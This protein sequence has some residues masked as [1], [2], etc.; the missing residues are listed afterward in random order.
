[1]SKALEQLKVTALQWH[2]GQASPL[3]AFGCTATI[4]PGMMDEIKECL[5][6]VSRKQIRQRNKLLKLQAHVQ[7]QL[8]KEKYGKFNRECVDNHWDIHAHMMDGCSIPETHDLLYMQCSVGS[9]R[10]YIAEQRKLEP[11]RWV[12]KPYHFYV[13]AAE[14]PSSSTVFVA[15]REGNQWSSYCPQ[16]QHSNIDP[17]YLTECKSIT[18][19]E[20]IKYSSGFYTPA[21]YLEEAEHAT[22]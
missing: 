8:D 19:E 14:Q 4:I 16:G 15:F 3:Y 11:D 2:R 5:V 17:R 9:L 13:D 12:R 18:K 1:M 21:E 10:K 20:Y 6:L 7:K 22:A